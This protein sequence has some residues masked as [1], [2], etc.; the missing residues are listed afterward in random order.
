MKLSGIAI[1]SFA[2]DKSGRLA[3]S[4]KRMS[5][6]KKISIRKSKRV[7]SARGRRFGNIPD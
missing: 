1:P 5:V 3:R 4:T 2:L 7:K 6:S